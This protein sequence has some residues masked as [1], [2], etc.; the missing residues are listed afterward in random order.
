MLFAIQS[1]QTVRREDCLPRH[2]QSP[3]SGD[4]VG[5]HGCSVVCR[6]MPFAFVYLPGGFRVMGV[7]IGKHILLL[8]ENWNFWYTYMDSVWIAYVSIWIVYVCIDSKYPFWE[9]LLRFLGLNI[10]AEH[11]GKEIC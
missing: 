5:L 1:L 6:A 8:V 10:S 2:T 3:V 11:S 4:S 7:L 9:G